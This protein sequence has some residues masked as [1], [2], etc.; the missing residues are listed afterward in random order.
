MTFRASIEQLNGG[1]AALGDALESLGRRAADSPPDNAL[2][3]AEALAD[4]ADTMAGWAAEAREALAA[5]PAAKLANA[6]RCT[7]R[8]AH[9]LADWAGYERMADVVA[10]GQEGGRRGHDWALDVR[11]ALDAC[12]ARHARV[13]RAVLASWQELAEAGQAGGVSVNNVSVGPHVS[14]AD[15][16]PTN[17]GE[18]GG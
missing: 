1:L 11:D 17:G 15:S 12:R 16:T 9:D 8:I 10:A 6:H 7:L 5:S 14:F 18:T 2:R 13:D 4:A 3:L